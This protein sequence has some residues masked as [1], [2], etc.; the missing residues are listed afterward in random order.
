MHSREN[1]VEGS[2]SVRT[3]N[4]S[5]GLVEVLKVA[6]QANSKKRRSSLSHNRSDIR[7]ESIG[8]DDNSQGAA[9][10]DL[11]PIVMNNNVDRNS[12]IFQ[13]HVVWKTQAA[14]IL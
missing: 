10:M 4:M 14:A 12:G 13:S 5:L 2:D 8:V 9:R 1:S 3:A 11:P 6:A 7:V